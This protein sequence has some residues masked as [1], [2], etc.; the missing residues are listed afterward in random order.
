MSI[1]FES[2]PTGEEVEDG[3]SAARRNSPTTPLIYKQKFIRHQEDL[4]ELL[5]AGQPA[6][7]R[8][9]DRR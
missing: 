7:A 9:A 6:V 5:P 4:G 2:V 1:P 8:P 3:E